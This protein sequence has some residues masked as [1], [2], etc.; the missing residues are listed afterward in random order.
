MKR[1]FLQDKQTESEK[2]KNLKERDKE[3]EEYYGVKCAAGLRR[4]AQSNM[5]HHDCNSQI[6]LA[7]H[8][9]MS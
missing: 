3:G 8:C 2:K 5:G 9:F 4:A 6:S 7:D 1:R